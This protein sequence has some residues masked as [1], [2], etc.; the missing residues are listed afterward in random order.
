MKKIYAKVGESAQTFARECP[1][2]MIEMQT[3]RPDGDYI[4]GADG[5]WVDNTAATELNRTMSAKQF[6]ELFTIDELVAIYQH[7]DVT[8]PVRIWLD[9]L[10][11]AEYVVRTDTALQE[12]M[13]YMVYQG[14][15]TQARYNE[16]MIP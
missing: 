6:M 14:L 2:D 4:A 11:G 12:G 1:A 13:A 10:T 3:S 16:I 5:K 9:R 15:I 7:A 8:L